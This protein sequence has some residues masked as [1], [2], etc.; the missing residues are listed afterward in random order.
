MMANP[1]Q[2]HQVFIS[3][4]HKDKNFFDK[5]QTSLKPL[6]SHNKISVWDDTKIQYGKK[7]REEI[8]Q[9]IASAKVAVLLVSPDFIASDFIAEHE[10]P[11]LL[12]AAEKEGLTI[13]WIALR[14]SLYME[15]EIGRYQAVNDP[16]RP[17]AGISAANREKEIVRICE[18][19][20]AAALPKEE[21]IQD[22]SRATAAS[23]PENAR[24]S[25]SS[26]T[27]ADIGALNGKEVRNELNV[28]LRRL[29]MIGGTVSLGVT[30][31]PE[32][33]VSPRAKKIFPLTM[34]ALL[35]ALVAV[36][37]FAIW[38]LTRNDS[39]PTNTSANS[40][41]VVNNKPVPAPASPALTYS[42][43]V[44]K[45]F[46]GRPVGTP[47]EYS[48]DEMFGNGWKFKFNVAPVE[49]GY[50]YLLNAAPQS[51]GNTEWNV[52]FPTPKTN[53]GRARMSGQQKRTF[54]WYVFDEK[55][56]QEKLWIIWSRQPI[57]ELETAVKAATKTAL[58]IKE[59]QHLAAVTSFLQ[60]WEKGTP[61]LTANQQEKQTV[62]NSDL[63][64]WAY[65]VK[66]RHDKY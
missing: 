29:E 17:L 56:G 34:V 65:L 49:G 19:I 2:R 25:I 11:P 3:Y 1:P 41:V 37:G 43:T 32:I 45:V 39:L 46:G 6:V 58:V 40:S 12:E 28:D 53:D 42:L 61:A 9:A 44:Q 59:P 30:D 54:G 33:P 35:L 4:S 38:R 23:N 57:Q 21:Q 27:Q 22:Q 51:D 48:G 50:V 18:I 14:H 66:L 10:L 60:P 5:L 26:V 16:S 20:K 62:I 13:L 47:E 64:T 52:L 55:P 7:W 8:E 36:A 24:R 15:T 31:P 63:A